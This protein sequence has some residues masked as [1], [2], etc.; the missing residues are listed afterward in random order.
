MITW[1]QVK[2]LGVIWLA[3]STRFLLGWYWTPQQKAVLDKAEELGREA[4]ASHAR[5]P[6]E[7]G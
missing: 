7:Q 6:R 2:D 1:E 5:N 4:Y 3:R